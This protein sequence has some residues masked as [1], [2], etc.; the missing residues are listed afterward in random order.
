MQSETGDD[1]RIEGFSQK[2]KDKNLSSGKSNS[3]KLK[4]KNSGTNYILLIVTHE[5]KIYKMAWKL[6][7]DNWIYPVNC[8]GM[9]Y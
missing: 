5:I 8:Y 2:T 6:L 4:L 7:T 3:S 9:Y 1:A